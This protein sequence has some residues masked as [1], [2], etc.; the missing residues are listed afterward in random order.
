[1]KILP[2]YIGE[3]MKRTI[4]ALTLV[5]IS[6]MIEV[7]IEKGGIMQMVLEKPVAP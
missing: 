6:T 1:L 3:C 4:D 7:L 5:L 2:H